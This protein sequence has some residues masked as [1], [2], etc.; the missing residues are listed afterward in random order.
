M[1]LLVPSS[2]SSQT[3]D[4]NVVVNPFI[5]FARQSFEEQYGRMLSIQ[6]F[7][8]K[9]N[10]NIDPLFVDEQ[11]TM[12]NTIRTDELILITPEMIKR[13]NF[14]K[15]SNFLRKLELLFPVNRNENNEYNGDGV[16]VLKTCSHSICCIKKHTR[17]CC[18]QTSSKY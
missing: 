4:E 13:L 7:V 8:A 12:M 2:Q 5:D 3:G 14:S 17:L 16:N 10:F 15:V 18:P 11:W 1:D 9:T 6:S